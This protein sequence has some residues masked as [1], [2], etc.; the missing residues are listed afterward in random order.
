MGELIDAGVACPRPVG[1][2][3]M[4]KP[5]RSIKRLLRQQA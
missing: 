5:A 2:E 3:L 1:G 4:F